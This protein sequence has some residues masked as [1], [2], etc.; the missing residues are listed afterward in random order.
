MRHL[1]SRRAGTPG[2]SAPPRPAARCR[3]AGRPA[4]RSG[5]GR[6]RR[7][8]AGRGQ[9]GEPLLARARRR[10]R[11]RLDQHAGGLRRVRPPDAC[12]AP[13]DASRRAVCGAR[14]R[15]RTAW[16]ATTSTQRS[17][18]SSGWV[19]SRSRSLVPASGR[20][21]HARSTSVA[22]GVR[23][24]SG[25]TSDEDAEHPVLVGGACG[26]SLE[27]ERTFVRGEPEHRR[28]GRRR[29]AARSDPPR[30]RPC[31]A[32]RSVA[33]ASAPA[34]Q[35]GSNQVRVVMR[36]PSADVRP[37]RAG[38]RRA[39]RTPSAPTAPRSDVSSQNG[40][41][42]IATTPARVGRS[43]QNAQPSS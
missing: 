33:H 6:G 28:P 3:R 17:K 37:P 16:S 10:R 9:P 24:C 32:S 12:P 38:P 18:R 14:V 8:R 13:R 7:A 30:S 36:T 21:D 5:D 26:G 2:V 43:R 23:T 31:S 34:R 22:R 11:A 39:C 35:S 41:C 29:A 25:A 19:S 42:G 1:P 40:A 4:G 27:P 15:C 20:S